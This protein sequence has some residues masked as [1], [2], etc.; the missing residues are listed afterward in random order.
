[1]APQEGD[2][3]LYAIEVK[4]SRTVRHADLRGLRQFKSD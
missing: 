2:D 1:M 3:G 4:R